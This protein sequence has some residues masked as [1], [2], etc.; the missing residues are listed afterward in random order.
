MTTTLPAAITRKG[1]GR[2][3]VSHPAARV[4]I[5]A[6]K[7]SDRGR[8]KAARR[9]G[10][11]ATNTRVL[12][13]HGYES[14]NVMSVYLDKVDPE[15]V[16]GDDAPATQWTEASRFRLRLGNESEAMIAKFAAELLDLR[17]SKV[18]MLQSLMYPELIAS[19]DRTTSDGALCELK[20]T[21]SHYLLAYLDKSSSWTNA[22]GWTLPGS[23]RVQVQHQLAVSG[24]THAY[25]AALVTD[26]SQMTAWV[27]EADPEEQ[28]QI[29]ELNRR[30]WWD[31]VVPRK[32]PDIDWDT[33]TRQEMF[34]RFPH[35][36]GTRTVTGD[37]LDVTLFWIRQRKL[38]KEQ[39]KEAKA[40]ADFAEN[41]LREIH[42]PA[43][44]LYAP[45]DPRALSK[46]PRMESVNYDAKRLA[47]D[48]AIDLEP[49]TNRT[50]YRKF[51]SVRDLSKNPLVSLIKAPKKRARKVA[52]DA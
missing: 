8:W 4:L 26:K 10:M 12:M 15:P 41:H 43:A 50:P 49:Y 5:P 29:V 31:C 37:E 33:V 18:G 52:P 24:R 28:G 16:D 27:V 9:Q 40:L 51:T 44:E 34:L 19:P 48:H 2:P 39:E 11:T 1:P 3:S 35:A 47:L 21:S 32:V 38:A 23:W 25:V 30:F 36:D 22:E 14:E 46:Y 45:N 13:G 42:G 7:L 17:M 20:L 6:A